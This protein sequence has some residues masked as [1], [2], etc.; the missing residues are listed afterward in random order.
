M[1]RSLL[2][3]LVAASASAQLPNLRPETTLLAEVREKM[4]NLLANQPNYTCLETVER[5]R[6][7]PGGGSQV[8]DTLRLEVA[9]VEGKEMFAWP[10]AK[11]FEDKNIRELVSTGMFGNGNYAIYSRMLFNAAGPDFVYQGRVP[12]LSAQLARYDFRVHVSRSGYHLSSGD[13]EAVTGF[14]GSI[15]LDPEKAELRRLEVVAD[16]IPVELG[17]TSAEDRVDYASV[18]IGDE[19]FL[20]P[21]ESALQMSSK[22]VVSRNRVRFSGCR[23]F[24]GESSLIFDDPEVQEVAAPQAVTEVELPV[25]ASISLEILTDLRMDRTAVGDQVTAVLR[26]DIK[27]GKEVVV[28]KGATVQG[29][30]TMLERTPYVFV[31]GLSFHELEWKGGHAQ[32]RAK[33]DGLA[34]FALA[35]RPRIVVT[36]DGFIQAASSQR[37]MR[38]ETLMLRTVR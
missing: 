32:L 2:F 25:G 11:Q 17:I 19:T 14:H 4:I 33:L 38:G 36:P 15:Y 13:R 22:D 1:G 5:T 37:S 34:G 31:L 9:L 21:V 18:L 3:L 30:V 7:A 16:D 29:R 10:G 24:T 23:K 28:K 35:G 12:L 6:Q 26:S 20:L 27:R 8:E